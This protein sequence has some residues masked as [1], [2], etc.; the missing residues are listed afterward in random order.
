MKLEVSVGE[1]ID[2]YSILELKLKKIGDE[3]KNIEIE[4]EIETLSECIM[5]KN[6]YSF[7]YNLLTYVN[8]S[9]WDMTNEIKRKTIEDPEFAI[10]SN[11]IFEFNQKRFRIKNWFN[12]LTYSQLKEQKSY[13]STYC[14]IVIENEETIYNKIA[15]IHYL[16]LEYDFIWFETPYLDVIQRIFTIPTFL[17]ETNEIL[18]HVS[19]QLEEY[20]IKDSIR[21][22]FELPPIKYIMGGLFGDFIQTL[23]VINENFYITG[24]KGII[25]LSDRCDN[26]TRGVENTYQDTHLI[27]TKQ[28]YIH[29]YLIYDN[30]E[31]DID[32]T[33]WRNELDIFLSINPEIN[34]FDIFKHNYNINWGKHRWLTI[35]KEDCFKDVVF[36][37]TTNYRWPVSINFKLLYETYGNNLVFIGYVNQYLYF[38]KTTGIN[39]QFLECNTFDKLCSAI[40]SCKLFIGSL[41]G[42]LSLAHACHKDRIIGLNDDNNDRQLNTNLDKE[43]KN[44]RYNV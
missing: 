23:S 33:S 35:E 43:W 31:Y 38:T 21:P 39:V 6:E 12:L 18:N 20:V 7:L 4:K 9:I 25:Y 22:I 36:I 42:P 40:S 44:V 32:L 10:I 41:S 30:E 14:K 34:W 26:F 8:E 24:R 5:Y 15:E 1:A 29:S 17:Y 28:N 2:K 16:S 13:S 37:N 11:Q 19:I 3:N 27:I